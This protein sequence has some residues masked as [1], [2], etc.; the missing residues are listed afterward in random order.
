[1]Y[2]AK[3]TRS[4]KRPRKPQ[5]PKLS[6]GLHEDFKRTA[7]GPKASERSFG[8]VFSAV[9]ALT[10]F[11]PLLG[12]HPVRWWAVGVSAAFL[13]LALLAPRTLIIPNRLW[14]K[15]GELLHHIVSPVVMSLL[16]IV[17]VVPT[18]LILRLL[19]RDPLRLK[20]DKKAVTYWQNREPSEGASFTQQF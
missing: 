8:F 2:C 5:R 17:A 10:G 7:D 20:L 16:F 3:T 13:G 1:M 14:M 15:F 11:L 12:S 6:S 18:A 4:T 19:G 9:F